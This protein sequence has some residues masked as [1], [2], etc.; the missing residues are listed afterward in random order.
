MNINN[1]DVQFEIEDLGRMIIVRSDLNDEVCYL[2]YIHGNTNYLQRSSA[3]ILDRKVGAT[4]VLGRWFVIEWHSFITR[5]MAM[6]RLNM[7]DKH[8]RKQGYKF[9]T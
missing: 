8:M 6:K 5:N 2:S 7:F 9:T 1:L 3:S 4:G